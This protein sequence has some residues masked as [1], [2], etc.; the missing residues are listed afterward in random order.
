MSQPFR[1]LPCSDDCSVSQP[2]PTYAK[3][4]FSSIRDALYKTCELSKALSLMK[5]AQEAD[6]AYQTMV[7]AG[8]SPGVALGLVGVSVAVDTAKSM[9]YNAFKPEAVPYLPSSI[10]M[11]IWALCTGL[12]GVDFP[13][14]PIPFYSGD[15]SSVPGP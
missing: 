2:D 10:G 8:E 11:G 12:F 15:H 13:S 9:T 6:E 14:S 4:V 1:V 5:T 7:A 3:Q